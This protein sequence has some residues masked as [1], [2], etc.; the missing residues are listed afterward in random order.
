MAVANV[1]GDHVGG[2]APASQGSARLGRVDRDDAARS[3]EPQVLHDELTE[4]TQPDHGR[5]LAELELGATDAELGGA[6]QRRPAGLL[7]GHRL[8]NDDAVAGRHDE[9]RVVWRARRHPVAN[10]DAADVGTD[11]N[12]LATSCC[13]PVRT[14]IGPTPPRT[15]LG[16]SCRPGRSSRCRC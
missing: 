8:G 2:T 16:R 3:A 7:V 4:D 12:H 14:G 13:S 5:A 15:F 10:R 9:G 1:G 11:V 6:C